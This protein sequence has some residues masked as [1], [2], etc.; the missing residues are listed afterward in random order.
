METVTITIDELAAIIEAGLLK[1]AR[2]AAAVTVA[3]E[4]A[5]A[6]EPGEPAAAPVTAENAP[7]LNGAV[8]IAGAGETPENAPEAAPD[9]VSNEAPSAPA[10]REHD[11]E[12]PM[13][14]NHLLEPIG[15][16]TDAQEY[17]ACEVEHRGCSLADLETVVSAHGYVKP[18]ATIDQYED[19]LCK[20]LISQLHQVMPAIQQAR[21]QRLQGKTA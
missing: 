3:L 10:A 14:R 20:W 12:V 18:G 15:Y 11:P 21:M 19:G 6:A 17:L 4:T 1:T 8:V 16:L 9:A 7:K 2:G 13:P 5:P